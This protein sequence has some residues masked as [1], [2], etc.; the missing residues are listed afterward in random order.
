MVSGLWAGLCLALAN[1]VAN[2][3]WQRLERHLLTRAGL[4]CCPW[5]VATTR[6][7]QGS[8][9]PGYL[10]A[11]TAPA[12][13]LPTATHQAGPIWIPKAPSELPADDRPRR[14]PAMTTRLAQS[15]TAQQTHWGGAM[16]VAF[17]QSLLSLSPPSPRDCGLILESGWCRAL[18][19]VRARPT[20]VPAEHTVTP[21]AQ[22]R[23]ASP[24]PGPQPPRRVHAW[25]CP[26]WRLSPHQGPRTEDRR[27]QQLLGW[28][29]PAPQRVGA[30]P[31][32]LSPQEGE[33]AAG[34]DTLQELRSQ[35][36]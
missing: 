4:S 27:Q 29:G 3:T 28:N 32:A 22:G 36:L 30:Q 25:P 5:N 7:S 33:E 20:K 6:S 16:L 24:R 10:V 11:P 12:D 34:G 26:S 17:N 9:S 8:P 2:V 31:A 21:R 19:W 18:R 1:E 15:R 13:S 23:S 35:A 14:G